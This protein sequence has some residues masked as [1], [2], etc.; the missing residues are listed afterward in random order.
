MTYDGLANWPKSVDYESAPLQWSC[1]RDLV[2]ES[3]VRVASTAGM[4]SMSSSKT[5][6]IDPQI[7]SD[8]R[9]F[10]RLAIPWA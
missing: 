5:R 3:N 7:F 8:D 6:E 10:K 4:A 9:R 2:G 1:S